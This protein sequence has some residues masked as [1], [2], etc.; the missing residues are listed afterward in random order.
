M[1]YSMSGLNTHA[2]SRISPRRGKLGGPDEGTAAPTQ[3]G[4]NGERSSPPCLEGKLL[5]FDLGILEDICEHDFGSLTDPMAPAKQLFV[6]RTAPVGLHQDYMCGAGKRQSARGGASCTDGDSWSARS[7]ALV[8]ERL[9]HQQ[10]LE[11]YYSGMPVRS[12]H[13]SKMWKV[14]K[15]DPLRIQTI[16]RARDIGQ[17][18][19]VLPQETEEPRKGRANADGLCH[20]LESGLEG[21]VHVPT[22]ALDDSGANSSDS[23]TKLFSR[24]RRH[25]STPGDPPSGLGLC[26]RGPTPPQ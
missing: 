23:R 11:V 24:M 3:L 21:H 8:F 14:L 4:D 7:P 12:S 13:Q 6:F 17:P 19:A 1:L 25:Y 16:P 15:Y 20:A 5:A 10:V 2:W 26:W 18:P 22:P 9:S